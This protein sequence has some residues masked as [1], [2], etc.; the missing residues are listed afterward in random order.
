MESLIK[1]KI[2]YRIKGQYIKKITEKQRPMLIE[3]RASVYNKDHD[4]RHAYF[5]EGRGYELS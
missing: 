4:K 5:V 1:Y 3:Q 2:S